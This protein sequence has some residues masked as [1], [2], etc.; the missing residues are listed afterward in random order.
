MDDDEDCNGPP[1]KPALMIAQ[2]NI[3]GTMYTWKLAAHYF[4]KQPDDEERDRS[5]IIT[6]SMGSYTDSPVNF[7]F[8]SF[9]DWKKIWADGVG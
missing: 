7:N 4:R 8:S 1:V 6:G 5:F 2:V 3:L 9:D